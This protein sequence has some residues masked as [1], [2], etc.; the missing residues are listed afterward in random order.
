MARSNRTL[1]PV[2]LA[3][4]LGAATGGLVPRTAA[5]QTAVTG[6]AVE[7]ALEPVVFG[8]QAS[9]TGRVIP[10]T[11]FGAPP[12]LEVIVDLSTATARGLRSGLAYQVQGQSIL[13]RPLQPFEQVEVGVSFAP[14]GDLLQARS[15]VATFDVHYSAAKGMTTTP[16]KIVSHP[17]SGGLA[18]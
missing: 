7:R 14:Q 16:V 13:H 18:P 10:D 2:L 5:A 11:D 1:A 6:T 3:S 4:V 9:I 17:A 15:A 12:V 8:G